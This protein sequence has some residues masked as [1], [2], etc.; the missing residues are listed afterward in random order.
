MLDAFGLIIAVNDCDIFYLGGFCKSK[1]FQ[2]VYNQFFGGNRMAGGYYQFQAPK[3][4]FCMF[5]Q[6]MKNNKVKY[7]KIYN[8]L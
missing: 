5:S 2:Y 8:K 3:L 6:Q 4:D 1:L 7:Q